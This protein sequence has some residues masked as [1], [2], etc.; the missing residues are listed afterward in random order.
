MFDV[1]GPCLLSLNELRGMDKNLPAREAAFDFEPVHGRS[2]Y[3]F[4]QLEMLRPDLEGIPEIRLPLGYG[5]RHFQ[6]GDEQAW[7]EIMSEAFTPYWSAHRFR[8]LFLPHFGFRPERVLFLCFRGLPVGSASA[9]QWPGVSR[10]CGYIHMLGIK[11]DHC[12]QGLG[13]WLTVACLQRFKQEGFK[14]AMLQTEDYRIP[15][16]KHYLMLGFGPVLVAEDQRTKWVSIISRVGGEELVRKTRVR[17]LSV[18]SSVAFWW[19]TMLIVNYMSWLNLKSRICQVKE[20]ESS[21]G[22]ERSEER[23]GY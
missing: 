7:G 20:H 16:I 14:N 12:G 15:A 9:F 3:Q 8:A 10:E 11:K 18:M 6:P 19:R 4:P 13:Y 22:E 23:S 2:D 21:R 5:L 17:E 1:R